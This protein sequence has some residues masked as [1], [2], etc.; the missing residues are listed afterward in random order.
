MA[1]LS[2]KMKGIL[3]LLLSAFGFAVMSIFVK[4]S[5]DL[6]T[7]Q[8]VFFRNLI[9]MIFSL[10]LILYYRSKLINDVQHI[11]PLLLRSIFGTLGMIAYFYAMDNMVL[12]DANML[13]KLSTFFL[14]IFSAVFLKER[15]KA[16]Q[17]ISVFIAF[18]GALFII[19]PAFQV[20]LIPYL[21]SISAAMLAGA[22]YTVLRYLRN[23]EAYYSITF[24]FSTFSV[25]VI[26]PFMMIYYE[27]MNVYQ[28][29]YL[30][31]AGMFASIGQFGIT[32]AY[33]YAPARDIS[34]FNYFNVIFVTV[35]SYIV[36]FNFPDIYSIIGYIIIFSAS[37]YMF[38]KNKRI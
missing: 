31:L 34:I 10:S 4:L 38:Q 15:L 23:K 35:L 27:Q 29:I 14:L 26:L 5:G 7:I 8:K 20:D 3:F 11:P 1:H 12:S 18:I 13:N 28:V 17:V 32:I 24:F 22:A 19:K 37:I 6:P 21:A 16:Y 2:S 33:Q 30:L 36:F 25:I 9:T